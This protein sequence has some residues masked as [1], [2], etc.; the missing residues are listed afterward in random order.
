MAQFP[1][2]EILRCSSTPNETDQHVQSSFASCPGHASLHMFCNGEHATGFISF[3]LSSGVRMYQFAW[4]AEDLL[5]LSS[6]LA[7]SVLS[8]CH[9]ASPRSQSPERTGAT[10]LV[11]STHAG[12][13]GFWLE[14]VET[15]KLI[16]DVWRGL[17]IRLDVRL[18][19]V[20]GLQGQSPS[21]RQ[22]QCRVDGRW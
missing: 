13:T 11:A 22:L 9:G 15:V 2:P 7:A 5:L 20:L 4:F 19:E 18:E 6:I 17:N 16:S 8:F 14:I 10:L 21:H 1:C 3:T 12:G